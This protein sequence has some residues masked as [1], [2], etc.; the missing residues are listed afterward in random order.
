MR[1]MKS[2]IQ[3]ALVGILLT[4]IFGGAIFGLWAFALNQ[5]AGY[6]EKTRLAAEKSA[7]AECVVYG[8]PHVAVDA[9]GRAWC[10]MIYG[11]SE[12]LIPLDT[13]QILYGDAEPPKEN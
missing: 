3:S 2:K 10:Y 8:A 7:L 11:G 12:K 6:V 4:V 5:F 1:K 9:E 13:L